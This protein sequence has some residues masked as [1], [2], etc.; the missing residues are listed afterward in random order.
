LAEDAAEGRRPRGRAPKEPTRALR[1]AQAD[2]QAAKVREQNATATLAKLQSTEAVLRAERSVAEAQQA[3]QAAPAPPEPQANTTDPESRIMKTVSGWV[4][5]YNAQAAVNENQVVIAAS[6]STDANDV[7]QL[8]PM[9]TA[10]ESNVANARISGEIGIVLADAGYWSVGNAT[11]PGP[12]RLIATA[13]D[14]KQRRA[15][16][17]MGT[18][19]GDAPDGASPLD[20]MEHRLRTEAGAAEYAKRSYTVEPIFGQVK[21]NRNMRRFMRRGLDA[22]SSEWSLICATTNILKMFAYADGRSLA[23]LLTPDP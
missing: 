19:T 17:E 5:G 8:L 4:Q 3:A 6:V 9:I 2:L 11:T 16:R 12:D 15:A 7:N 14:W 13:K 23:G 20:A 18:T 21:E 1:R 22:A 10:V